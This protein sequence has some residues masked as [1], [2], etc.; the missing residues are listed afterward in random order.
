MST[1][2]IQ[3]ARPIIQ[4]LLALLVLKVVGVTFESYR[5]YVPPDFEVAFL[6]GRE[7]YFFSGYQWSFYPHIVAGP[8]SLLLGLLL[9]S[10]RFRCWRPHWHRRLGRVQ[11]AIVLLIVVPS[12]LAMAWY[13]AAGPGAGVG[14]ASLA[15]ATGGTV[16]QGWRAAVQRRF[17][18]HR[19]WM[20]RCFALLFSAVVI[21]VNGGLGLV[22]GIESEWYY[23]Q[24]AW[25][26]WLLPLLVLE[27]WRR[28]LPPAPRSV[29]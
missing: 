5:D 7:G 26:S 29:P 25:T 10:E 17:E 1:S 20:Q 21:R 9:L 19:R 12:G 16:I 3:R 24:T 18:D 11:V 22:C 14:F 23:L 8:C 13:A 28:Y 27:L 15:V 2:W 6:I 4:G